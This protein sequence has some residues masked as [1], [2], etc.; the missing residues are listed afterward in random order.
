MKFLLLGPLLLLY[1]SMCHTRQLPTPQNGIRTMGELK[2][3]HTQNKH[4]IHLKR[5]ANLAYY[6]AISIGTPPQPFQVVFDTRSSW[7]WVPSAFCNISEPCPKQGHHHYDHRNSKTYLGSSESFSHN[8]LAH[9]EGWVNGFTSNDTVSVAGLNVAN[10]E[11]IEATDVT[12]EFE[13]KPFDGVFGLQ[14]YWG[15]KFN[16]SNIISQLC[17]AATPHPNGDIKFSFYLNS[18]IS[19]TNAGELMLCGI[20]KTKFRGELKYVNTS[21]FPTAIIWELQIKTI[22]M[23]F[24]NGR[25]AVLDPSIQHGALIDTSK[26]FILGP[27]RYM[28]EIYKVINANSSSKGR[29]GEIKTVDCGNIDKLPNVTFTLGDHNFTLTGNDYIIKSKQQ[30]HEMICIVGFGDAPNPNQ[31]KEKGKFWFIGNVFLRKFYS[32]FDLKKGRIGFAESIK[33]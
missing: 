33:N 4:I 24:E 11:F 17:N 13:A 27:K 23:N 7:L 29:N 25:N 2:S 19:D 21:Q 8:K 26:P 10:Q 3:Y 12:R 20:D 9:I 28:R 15:P 1:I 31:N 22:T 18:N 32:V 30:N 5:S 16:Q 14:P 6:G